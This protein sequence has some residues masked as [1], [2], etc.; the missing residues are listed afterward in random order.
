M[1][2]QGSNDGGSTW[3]TYYTLPAVTLDWFQVNLPQTVAYKQLRILDDHNG[4]LNLSELE[5]KHWTADRALIPA[6]EA[7]ITAL[8]PS[9]YTSESWALL[10]GELSARKTVVSDP[11][12]TQEQL[13]AAAV[14]IISAKNAL[15]AAA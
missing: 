5:F 15:L 3:E 12:S 2:F 8:D 6:L 10:Q 14:K 1:K 9:T 11:A 7:E 4:R 13:D